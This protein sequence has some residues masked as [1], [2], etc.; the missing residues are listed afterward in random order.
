VVEGAIHQACELD[1]LAF[2]PGNVSVQ[3]PGHGMTAEDFLRSAA[4]V[5]PTIATP[6]LSV[7]ERILYSVRA[8]RS[9]V[10][11]NTNLGIVLLCAPLVQAVLRASEA[12]TLRPRLARVLNALDRRD[13]ELAYEAIRL[14][15][16]AGLGASER[17]DVRAEPQ[18]TLRE[19]MG[20]AG[21][22]DRIAY[23]YVHEFQDVMNWGVASIRAYAARWS[24]HPEA[25]TWATTGCYL[26]FLSRFLDSHI[27][28]KFGAAVAARASE[29]A[30][31][32]ETRVKACENFNNAM[33]SLQEFDNNLKR[34]GLNPGTSA[35]LT[36]ASLLAFYLENLLAECV[37]VARFHPTGG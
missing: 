21:H 29:M 25:L 6:H 33:P 5:A 24:R 28:R 17:H 12:T 4:R 11:C 36:V 27:E 19:A 20:E 1:V 26:G 30:K 16:P 31:R 7:G 14:A 35:D 8:T 37:A 32:V 34:E 2:K 23:Q 15:D 13:A 10:G 22:R 9:E 3:S 18:V